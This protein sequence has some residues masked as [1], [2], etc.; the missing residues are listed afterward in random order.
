MVTLTPF[1]EP[2]E[3]IRHAQSGT[4]ACF[5]NNNLGKGT[6]YIAESRLSWISSSGNG[7]ALEYPQISLHAISRDLSAY[8]QECLFLM[9]DDQDSECEQDNDSEESKINE[10]RFIPDDKGML[11][12]MFHAMSACQTLHPDPNNSFSE[13][14]EEVD[15]EADEGIENDDSAIIMEEADSQ[16]G[17]LSLEQQNGHNGHSID[18]DM[19]DD[20]YEDADNAHD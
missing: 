2:T 5:N 17:N 20:C 11:D 3:G 18:A 8:P 14:E 9:L 15:D 1:T 7:F 6:L 19:E 13:E 10:L 4:T 12:A 16:M